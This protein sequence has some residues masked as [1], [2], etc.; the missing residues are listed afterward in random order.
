MF[1]LG[2]DPGLSI[3]GYALVATE[4]SSMRA[5]AAGVLRTDRD[6][7]MSVRLAELFGDLEVLIAEHRPEE[8]AIERVFV[9]RNLQTAE[10]V[11]RASGVVLLAAAR[12][13]LEVY[14]YTPSAVKKAIVGVGTA[15]KKQIQEIVARRLGLQAA[16]APADAADALAVAMC[17]L[18]SAPLQRAIREARS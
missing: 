11:G 1:V 9:N 3:T 12:A 16:P 18:Q 5:V 17:H 10:S 8:V 2:I 7:P 15:P 4:G 13:G 6:L 14:E